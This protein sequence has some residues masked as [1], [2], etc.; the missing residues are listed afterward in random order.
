MHHIAASNDTDQLLISVD[1][2]QRL[3][4]SYLGIAFGNAVRQFHHWNRRVNRRSDLVHHFADAPLG[5]RIDAV[6]A[7]YVI[8]SPRYFF[9]ENRTPQQQHGNSMSCNTAD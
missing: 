5:Q 7:H 8:A 4:A 2:Q 9:G 6:L 3:M 1:D